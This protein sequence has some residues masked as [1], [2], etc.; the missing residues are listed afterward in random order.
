MQEEIGLK[1]F[2]VFE[3]SFSILIYVAG[4]GHVTQLVYIVYT[5]AF[6]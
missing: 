6:C 2:T 5:R 3:K 1:S 4:E